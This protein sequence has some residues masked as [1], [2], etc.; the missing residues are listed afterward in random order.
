VG[1]PCLN[2]DRSLHEVNSGTSQVF[3]YTALALYG[4]FLFGLAEVLVS[5]KSFDS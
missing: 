1:A 2:S 3:T 4:A 5:G